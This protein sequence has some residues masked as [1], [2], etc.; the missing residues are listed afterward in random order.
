MKHKIFFIRKPSPK[1]TGQERFCLTL[2]FKEA[3]TE[4]VSLIQPLRIMGE[5]SLRTPVKP[6]NAVPNRS[7]KDKFSRRSDPL[8]N[9]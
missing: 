6:K 2:G 4:Y 9:G 5:K 1:N 7:S 3:S 8:M